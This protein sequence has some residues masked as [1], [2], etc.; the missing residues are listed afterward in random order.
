[1][2]KCDV[3]PRD[4]IAQV[5]REKLGRTGTKRGCDSGSCGMCTVRLDGKPIY[6]CMTPAWEAE[7]HTIETIEGIRS[8][9]V[10][11]SLQK[12]LAGRSNLERPIKIRSE[13]KVPA[14]N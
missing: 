8:N 14:S 1:M 6:T 10:L 4:Y 3:E 5:I 12:A 9:E 2:R 13:D 11:D 7:G